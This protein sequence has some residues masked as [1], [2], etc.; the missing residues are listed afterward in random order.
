[1]KASIPRFMCGLVVSALAFAASVHGQHFVVQK[2]GQTRQGEVL[3][4]RGG[5]IRIKIGPAETSIPLTGVQSVKMDPPADFTKL[6]ETYRQ[7]D[8]TAA[9][10]KLLDLLLDL[11]Q[12]VFLT[13]LNF[14]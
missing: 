10:P 14:K 11:L 5:S 9:L 1:M 2:D 6:V 3:G 12:A 7:G 13:P 4:V 8:A